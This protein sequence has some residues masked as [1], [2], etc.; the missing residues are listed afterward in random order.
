MTDTVQHD[1]LIGRRLAGYLIRREL[2]RGGMATVYVADQ[3]SMNR[4][5]AV[6]VMRRDLVESD[7]TFVNRFEREA[8]TI[9]ALE[10][11]HI[12]PVIDFGQAEGYI[13]LVMRRLNH[14]L[15]DY[16][17]EHRPIPVDAAARMLRQMASALDYAHERQVIHRDLKPGNILMDRQD[18]CFLA[19]F[20]IARLI[21]SQGTALTVEGALVGTPGYMAPEIITGESATALSDIYALGIILFEI[22]YARLPFIG[23]TPFAIMHQHLYTPVEI[24]KDVRRDI[25]ADVDFVLYRALA[26]QPEDRFE[27]AGELAEAFLMAIQQPPDTQVD[28]PGLGVVDT[29][30]VDT[31]I[32][33]APVT[34]VPSA[35]GVTTDMPVGD[36][37]VE[38][39]PPAPPPAPDGP[40]DLPASSLSQHA[41]PTRISGTIAVRTRRSRQWIVIAVIA[42]LAVLVLAVLVLTRPGEDPAP[43]LQAAQTAVAAG[44]PDE[45]R[46]GFRHVLDIAPDNA[47]ARQGLAKLLNETGLAALVAL[48]YDAAIAD[49]EE[50]I[51]VDPTY[52]AAHFNLG[53]AYEENQQLDAARAAYEAAL[54]HDDQLLVARYRLAALLLDMDEVDAG[55]QVIDTGLNMLVQ[56]QV[57]LDAALRDRLMF[58][59]Y[60]TH[61][62]AYYLK[63]GDRN[64]ALAEEDLKRALAWQDALEYPAEAYYYLA[65]IYDARGDAESAL[66]A[67]RNVLAYHDPTKSRHREWAVEAREHMK[68]SQ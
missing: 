12:L 15:K 22:L 11:V 58:L 5:V 67:W 47:E 36:G 19:D 64:L 14:S 21:D 61:G 63:G 46:A 18:N 43:H 56:G 4:E 68:P 3:L 38:T 30:I 57:E 51:T 10:H 50:A 1:P 31:A 59:M 23:E 60:T 45:A 7:A 37:V 52:A 54:E 24:P 62:R 20:G 42:W 28:A 17:Q 49:L 33:L 25:P 8:R 65:Q 29:E 32:D 41:A 16:I 39:P 44:H 9:A 26:K 34:P 35:P 2:G 53:V 66:L 13:Y 27:S 48:D 6:K 40:T 55:F